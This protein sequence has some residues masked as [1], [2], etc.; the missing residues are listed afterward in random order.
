MSKSLIY[1]IAGNSIYQD[2]NNVI[3]FQSGLNVDADGGLHSYN[4]SNTGLDDNQN[5]K[6]GN[7]WVGIAT[8]RNGIPYKD[9]QN[10]Y[11]STTSYQWSQYPVNDHRRYVDSETIPYIVIPPQIRRLAKGI[12]MGAKCIVTNTLNNKSIVGVV[13]DIGPRDSIGEVSIAMANLLGVNSNPRSGGNSNKV[14]N[15]Q[16][17]A[18]IP[19]VVNGITYNLIRA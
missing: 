3:T 10:Y 6:D 17:F 1:S 7:Q 11:I 9:I 16:I 5:A 12:V 2:L 4:P 8:D 18:D 19:A 13:A 15:Y 14:F